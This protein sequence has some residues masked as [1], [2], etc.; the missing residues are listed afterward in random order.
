MAAMSYSFDSY[1]EALGASYFA[2][3]PLLERLLAH[4]APAAL[5]ASD[6]RLRAW[7]GRCATELA[8]LAEESARPEN[9]PALRHFDAHN[10]RVDEVALPASTLRALAIAEGEERLGAL[11]GDPFVFY[12]MGYLSGQNGEAGFGCSM[13]CTD[14]LVRALEGLGDRPEHAEAAARVRGSHGGRVVH[15]AQFVTEIQGGSDVP[16]NALAARP[17][18]DRFRLSGQKWFCS[19]VNAD[20]FL[21]TARPEGAP[22]GG[23]GVALF[24]VP[25]FADP[26]AARGPRNG[27]TI[28]RLKDKLGTRELATAEVTF[29]D[30]L[31]TPVGPLDRGL[32]NL[33]HHVLATSRMGCISIAAATLRQAERVSGAYAS[34]R[35]AFGQP[36]RAFPLVRE[37]HARIA[38]AR[39]RALA[40]LLD[41]VR[42]WPHASKPDA[43]SPE[44]VAFR[45]MVSL[46][47]PALTRL[48][49]M[50]AHDAM[51]VM[52]ANGIEE[53]FSPLPRLF[54][55][56]VI[57]ETWEGPHDVLHTQALRDMARYEIDPAPFVARIAGEPRSD[58]ATELARILGRA[59][60]P[61]A[62]VAMAELGPRLVAAM[63]DRALAEAGAA[64]TPRA[65]AP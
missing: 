63:A 30:A 56:A 39:A 54:R 45:V 6:D 40:T 29:H 41:L 55:D 62:T 35:T 65:A 8:E 51:I 21:V 52:G 44:A 26:R 16:A 17:D 18:G 47:K 22:A 14:G 37:A 24:L 3:D 42:L 4:H 32:A 5:D 46:A 15:G 27:Y 53:R 7:G 23:R 49:T 43:A 28:D 61:E 36:I 9:A 19:N 64:G 60:D 31:A 25:A 34:F 33:L 10:H 13:A 59:R 57:M 2:D 1:R 50:Q 38:A 58:L 11:H 48:A 12:A 20:Y